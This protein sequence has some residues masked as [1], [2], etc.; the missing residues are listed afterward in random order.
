[1]QSIDTTFNVWMWIL[2]Q[3]QRRGFR[4]FVHLTKRMASNSIVLSAERLTDYTGQL[5][6]APLNTDR[7][8]SI[9]SDALK[10]EGHC[11]A[12]LDRVNWECER[13]VATR[14]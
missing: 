1:M 6:S 4:T 7:L 2:Q 3:E 12:L 9:L 10:L 5:A 14:K 13:C 8:A 11:V